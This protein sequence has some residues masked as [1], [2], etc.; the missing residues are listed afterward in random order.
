MLMVVIMRGF[1]TR[2][3]LDQ[4][5]IAPEQCRSNAVRLTLEPRAA[6]NALF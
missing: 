5:K 1:G 4:M 2:A 6:I 3:C